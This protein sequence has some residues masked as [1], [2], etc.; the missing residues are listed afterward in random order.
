VTDLADLAARRD[1]AV[2]LVRAWLAAP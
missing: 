2:H 1:A